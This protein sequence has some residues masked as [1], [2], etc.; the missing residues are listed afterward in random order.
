MNLQ[1]HSTNGNAPSV[2]FKGAL[3]KG[4][5][6]DRGL[7]MPDRF[8]QISSATIANFRNKRYPEIA[9]EVLWPYLDGVIDNPGGPIV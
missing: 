2:D 7:Y 6:P 4:Q 3:L 5:A 9:F 8:P 1:F